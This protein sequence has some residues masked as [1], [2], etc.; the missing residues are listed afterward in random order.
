M[1]VLASL[2]LIASSVAFSAGAASAQVVYAA[3]DDGWQTPPPVKP[4]VG[5]PADFSA[6]PLGPDF[7]FPGSDPFLGTIEFKGFPVQT[8]P[9]GQLREIDTIVRRLQDTPPMNIGDTAQVPVEIVALSLESCQPI[10]VT[11]NGQ[12]SEAW[13][14]TAHLS[15][16]VPQIPGQMTVTR[17]HPDGGTF[18]AQFLVRPR[19]VFTRIDDGLTVVLDP[20]PE[21]DLTS[22][23]HAFTEPGG[24]GGFDPFTRNLTLFGAGIGVDGDGDGIFERTTIGSSNFVA[25]IGTSGCDFE[26]ALS[27]EEAMLAA[28]GVF[29]PGDSD[30]VGYLEECDNCPGIQNPGQEDTDGDGMG[31]A[32]DPIDG[33][34]H[35]NELY[36]SH[37]GTDDQ[38]YI[39]LV[40]PGGLA[41]DGLMVLALEGDGP[42][43]VAGT[44]DLAVDLTGFVMPA[45]GFFVIGDAAV[46]NVDL[47]I[48]VSNTIENGTNTYML[49]LSSDPPTVAGLTG[50]DLDP[51]N[52]GVSEIKC[53]PEIVDILE[54]VAI[55]DGTA[56]DNK[57]YNGAHVNA[58]GPDGSFG[59]PG[60]YRGGDYPNP[61]C[62][63]FLD[64]DDVAN[65]AEPRTPGT[66]NAPCPT[67]KPDCP[68]TAEVGANFCFGGISNCPCGNAGLGDRGCDIQQGTGGVKLDVV[69][70]ETSPNNRVTMRG[71]GFP[72]ASA[73][74]AIV[75]RGGGPTDVVFGDGVLCIAGAV[76]R[77]AGTFASGGNSVHTFGH[78]T[79]AGSGDFYY[80]LW[81]RN[82]PAMFCTPDAFNLSNG[83]R[84]TW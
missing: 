41:L 18:S 46:P 54:T 64:F 11:T 44:L 27:P 66:T 36:I 12:D 35:F 47:V 60:I 83:T 3:G 16:Q 77:L 57:I 52:D 55:V 51:E 39:E 72:G 59:P 65:V 30:E 43:S 14:V 73:P 1:R 68:C 37:D 15:V 24:P 10:T 38:E 80:Q 17:S 23:G 4:L 78:G 8:N 53:I 32:C 56:G 50:V 63:A 19:F 6:D 28:H 20:A 75:I 33:A 67:A 48:G 58:L 21:I 2:A 61:W 29:P 70:R 45:D 13:D 84:L 79:M 69:R 7:F 62:G 49:V 76:T 31:D 26:W 81:F 74:T 22:S 40:G 25:G 71:S 42:T 34:V 82:T 9:P 5:T